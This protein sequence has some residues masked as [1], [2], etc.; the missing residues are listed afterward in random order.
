MEK[1]LPP[2]LTVTDR[3]CNRPHSKVSVAERERRFELRQDDVPL[4]YWIILG[5]GSEALMV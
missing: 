2:I 1:A 5:W 4:V 3:T